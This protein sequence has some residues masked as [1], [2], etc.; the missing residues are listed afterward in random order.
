M[1]KTTIYAI[2]VLFACTL[3]AADLKV[4][5]MLPNGSFETSSGW[6]FKDSQ[7]TAENPY[8]GKYCVEITNLD[9]KKRPSIISDFISYQ[10]GPVTVSAWL[11]ADKVVPGKKDWNIGLAHIYFY[12]K[13]KKLLP[14][15][16]CF[17]SIKGSTNWQ[18]ARR[19]YYPPETKKSKWQ[20]IRPG[21]KYIRLEFMLSNCTGKLFVD[22]V[23]LVGKLPAEKQ[24]KQSDKSALSASEKAEYQRLLLATRKASKIKNIPKTEIIIEDVKLAPYKKIQKNFPNVPK[25][26]IKGGDIYRNGKPSMLIGV[27]THFRLYPFMYKLLGMDY[28]VLAISDRANTDIEKL[29][30][31]KYRV[32]WRD[33]SWMR[34]MLKMLADQGLWAYIDFW[35][36]G[37]FPRD[38]FASMLIQD[39]PQHFIWLRFSNPLSRRYLYNYTK[40]LAK[41]CREYPVFA[42]ELLNEIMYTSPYHPDNLKLFRKD[43]KKK[44]STIGKANKAWGTGFKSFTQ[45]IPPKKGGV[46]GNLQN[47]PKGFSQNLFYEYTN[48][49]ERFLAKQISDWRKELKK[50]DPEGLV[51]VQATNNMW[52][53]YN[54]QGVNPELMIDSEDALGCECGI[55]YIPQPGDS[56]EEESIK[57]MTLRLMTRDVWRSVSPHKPIIDG[58]SPLST[59]VPPPAKPIIQLAGQWKF[60]SLASDT[61]IKET[62]RRP[63]KR[64]ATADWSKITFN[65][66]SW[67]PVKVPGMWGRQG[68][69]NTYIG[70]YRKTF[71]MSRKH[72]NA[73]L[74]GKRLSDYADIYVNGQLVHMTNHWDEDFCINVTK[75]LKPDEKNVIAIKLFNKYHNSGMYWGGIR[76]SIELTSAPNYL[77]PMTPGQMRSFIWSSAVHGYGAVTL[78]YF[79]S[80]EGITYPFALFNHTR[81]SREAMKAVPKI[82]KELESVAEIVLPRPRIKGKVGLF[83]P[84]E[85]FRYHVPESTVEMLRAPLS[86]ALLDYYNTL[87]FSQV[88][89]DMVTSKQI[90]AGKANKYKALLFRKADM[91]APGVVAKLVEYVN[92]GGIVIVDGNSLKYSEDFLRPENNLS[93]LFNASHKGKAYHVKSNIPRNK[94][95][96]LIGKILEDNGI[97]G[98][99]KVTGGKNIE[100][101][102]FTSKGKRVWYLNNW[103]AECMATLLP[104]N[105]FASEQSYNVCDVVTGR[106]VFRKTGKVLNMGTKLKLPSQSPVILLV[107]EAGKAPLP[108]QTLSPKHQEILSKVWNHSPDAPVKVLVDCMRSTLYSPVRAPSLVW[109]L[110]KNGFQVV[111]SVER[112]ESKVKTANKDKLGSSELRKFNIL[113]LPGVPAVGATRGYSRT[114][115]A[116]IKKFVKDGGS[117]LLSGQFMRGPHGHM[118]N[119]YAS[120]VAEM[121]GVKILRDAVYDPEQHILGEP[122]FVVYKNISG[123]LI[124]NGV[125]KLE[126]MGMAPLR[127]VSKNAIPI[128][129]SGL[130]S[131]SSVNRKGNIPAIAALEYGKGRVVIMGDASWTLP[132]MLSRSDNAQLILNIFNWLAHKP[133]KIVPRKHLQDLVNVD[134]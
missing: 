101:H 105:K 77:V 99:I 2:C 26:E 119:G 39:P 95:K 9:D 65:D 4:G 88:P 35:I 38:E 64:G 122:R 133:V 93:P 113:Y 41:I 106:M 50:Y 34:T 112:I 63:E 127:I 59:S 69:P 55:T 48:F 24:K 110:E 98:D 78:T 33:Y 23:K 66:E 128:V 43:M 125:K 121:F 72:G 115:L 94:R 68:F 120:K 8:Q 22:E 57:K 116:S 58:E 79:Y 5:N 126:T 85:Y 16:S 62:K 87:L 108:L 30:P 81:V 123:H 53:D 25:L 60:K 18:L 83:Y 71:T 118:S 37:P 7:L 76:G 96:T 51:L 70:L 129:R 46:I 80:G 124:A 19:T 73:Y 44:Y 13:D 114:E 100:A 47:L 6:T 40:S 82:K 52:L 111:N 130:S 92:N 49:S 21:T 84:F 109:L 1:L 67:K 56:A 75:L 3:S 97:T 28:I 14:P 131:R 74:T 103:G 20:S 107:E 45:V 12:D 61:G 10:D 134:F 11:K 91:V 27:E 86:G 15:H 36:G 104:L 32:S 17:K 29:G 132:S 117:L 42:Y 89:F 54:N 90:L 31:R 102:E